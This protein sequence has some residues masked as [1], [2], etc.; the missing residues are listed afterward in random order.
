MNP[1]YEVLSRAE[2][3]HDLSE[4]GLAFEDLRRSLTTS[5]ALLATKTPPFEQYPM[6]RRI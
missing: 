1:D 3:Q 6:K 2:Q 5:I 4:V